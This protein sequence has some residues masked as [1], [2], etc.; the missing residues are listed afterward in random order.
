MP[1]SITCLVLPAPSWYYGDPIYAA[2][3]LTRALAHQSHKVTEMTTDINGPGVLD[4]P[5][6]QPVWMDGVEVWYLPLQR[7]RAW[8]FFTPT[9]AGTRS[10]DTGF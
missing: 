2:F 4:V 6:G 3:G 8:G 10:T 9:W 7:P 5:L 1:T